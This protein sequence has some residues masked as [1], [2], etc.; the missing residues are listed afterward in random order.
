MYKCSVCGKAVL[1]KD[2]P[3]PVRA[4]KCTQEKIVNGEKVIAPSTI[5][6]DMEGS[7]YGK[8]QFKG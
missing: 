2:L 5:I 7:A 8:S 1:V 4:C 6:A 3:E